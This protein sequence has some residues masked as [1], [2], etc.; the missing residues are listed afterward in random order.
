MGAAIALMITFAVAGLLDYYGPEYWSLISRF[1]AIPAALIGALM[2][3]NISRLQ[4]RHQSTRDLAAWK[5]VLPLAL[6]DFAAAAQSGMLIA[7][8]KH[9]EQPTNSNDL[10]RLLS[11]QESTLQTLQ[12]CIKNSDPITE[13][14]LSLVIA[15]YQVYVARSDSM[16]GPDFKDNLGQTTEIHINQEATIISWAV[17]YALIEHHFEYSSVLSLTH[18]TGS[19]GIDRACPRRGVLW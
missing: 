5:A 14:W 17:L 3:W 8:K 9:P 15:H 2:A 7:A 1:V 10:K 4:V 6:S 11:L 13:K 18:L 19:L 16:L 12:N